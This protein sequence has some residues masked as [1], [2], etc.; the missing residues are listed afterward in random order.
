MSEAYVWLELRRSSWNAIVEDALFKT[1]MRN[2]PCNTAR[3]N[4]TSYTIRYTLRCTFA[5][6]LIV[7]S[8]VIG[9]FALDSS[10]LRKTH[11]NISN[12]NILANT[13]RSSDSISLSCYLVTCQTQQH[14]NTEFY[15]LPNR[16]RFKLWQSAE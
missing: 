15:L 8:I 3:K 12:A 11:D 7:S 9:H 14:E 2:A 5:R 16:G 6:R 10:V 1:E 4:N 13:H